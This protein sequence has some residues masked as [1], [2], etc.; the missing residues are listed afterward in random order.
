[1]HLQLN[2][3]ALIQTWTTAGQLDSRFLDPM[4]FNDLLLILHWPFSVRVPTAQDIQ[5]R[6][7]FCIHDLQPVGIALQ[8]S[9]RKGFGSHAVDAPR[10]EMPC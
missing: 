7:L 4:P 1:M 2:A 10:P 6:V 3:N 5:R 8:A 9:L